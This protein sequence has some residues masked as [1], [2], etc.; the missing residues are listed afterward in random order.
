MKIVTA[1]AAILIALGLSACDRTAPKT[2]STPPP[3]KPN[4]APS[5]PAKEPPKTTDPVTPPPA[6][7]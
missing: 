5:D 2:G 6:R 7:P 1:S 4:M 3:E